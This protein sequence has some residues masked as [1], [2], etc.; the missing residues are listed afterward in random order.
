MGEGGFDFDQ[1]LFVVIVF[2]DQID[3]SKLTESNALLTII[4]LF[5]SSFLTGGFFFFSSRILS[6]FGL[7]LGAGDFALRSDVTLDEL[8]LRV[9][10]AA[11]PSRRNAGFLC[12]I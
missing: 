10:T 8:A 4:H 6:G 5:P 2:L 12:V 11:P 3:S 9:G 7:L 1:A